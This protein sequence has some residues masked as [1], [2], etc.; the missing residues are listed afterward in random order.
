MIP[1]RLFRNRTI[2]LAVVA[3]IAVGVA[4][5]GASIFLSQYFQ[6]SRG[7]ARPCPV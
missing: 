4:M 6:I 3:S 7:R 5:F 2:T 1:L